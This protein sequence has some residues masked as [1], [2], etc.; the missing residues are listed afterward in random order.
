MAVK[1]LIESGVEWA[2]VAKGMA[3]RLSEEGSVTVLGQSQSE[4][5]SGVSG[6]TQKTMILTVESRGAK[7]KGS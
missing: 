2:D 7:K 5:P 1:I 6:F 4:Y 3:E